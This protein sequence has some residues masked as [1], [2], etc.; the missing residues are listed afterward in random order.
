L[1]KLRQRRLRNLRE[2][3][4]A[5]RRRQ[6][7]QPNRLAAAFHAALVMALAH[8]SEARLEQIV[9]DQ[10]LEAFGQAALGPDDLAHRRRQPLGPPQAFGL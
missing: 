7:L 2:V 6:M 1:R 5:R 8:A 10:R 4:A 9:T 3:V